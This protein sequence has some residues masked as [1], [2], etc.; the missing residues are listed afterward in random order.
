M[1]DRSIR[2]VDVGRD[3]LGGVSARTARA[4]IDREGIPRQRLRGGRYLVRE[5]DLR[6][7]RESQTTAS[8]QPSFDS[9]FDEVVERT[10]RKF[11]KAK[12]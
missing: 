8:A 3:W 5:D 6:K 1:N 10:L 12:P 9:V 4:V 11:R 2:D 7:W